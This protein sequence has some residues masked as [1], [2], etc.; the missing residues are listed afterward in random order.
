MAWSRS[1]CILGYVQ[2]VEVGKR[3]KNDHF[4]AGERRERGKHINSKPQGIF[5]VNPS[6]SFFEKYKNLCL[7]FTLFSFNIDTAF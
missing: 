2:H 3:V 6:F 7:I 5:H 1:F 4:K